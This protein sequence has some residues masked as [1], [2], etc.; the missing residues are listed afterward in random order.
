ME[1]LSLE[2]GSARTALVKVRL[3]SEFPLKTTHTDCTE[4]LKY[5]MNV[6]GTI[7]KSGLSRRKRT[8]ENESEH[9]SS[10]TSNTLFNTWNTLFNTS[11]TLSNTSNTSSNAS[12]TLEALLEMNSIDGSLENDTSLETTSAEIS[13]TKETNPATAKNVNTSD[14][15]IID[16]RDRISIET[17]AVSTNPVGSSTLVESTRFEVTTPMSNVAVGEDEVN[18]IENL[19]P[20]FQW[21][22][23]RKTSLANAIASASGNNERL[24]DVLSNISSDE[25]L[26]SL[27][28]FV[29]EE[30]YDD[31]FS[32]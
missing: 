18:K 21:P 1:V 16:D 14:E 25:D 4:Y 29:E 31:Y 11:N 9:L 12:N 10:Y 8:A 15:Q 20:K 24:A 27:E 17:L 7:H 23:Q 30:N 26:S 2:I 3:G 22:T 13:I 28:V 19:N 32:E 6:Q 5:L